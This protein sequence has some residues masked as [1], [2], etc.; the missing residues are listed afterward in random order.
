VVGL[1]Q[2][3]FGGDLEVIAERTDL[4]FQHY[5]RDGNGVW[6]TGPIIT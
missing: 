5:Y 6:N 3:S 2:S 4:K 1:I